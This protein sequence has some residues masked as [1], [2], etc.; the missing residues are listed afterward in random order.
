MIY[1]ALEYLEEWYRSD[2]TTR[3]TTDAIGWANVC[4]RMR[5]SE[6]APVSQILDFLPFDKGKA[7]EPKF[8]VSE[9]TKKICRHLFESRQLP[10]RVEGFLIQI[11]VIP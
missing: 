10:L 2:I 7:D 6:D 1:D 5:F 3:S 4:N 9:K 11:G 8:D